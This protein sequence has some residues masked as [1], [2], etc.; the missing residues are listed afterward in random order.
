MP[1]R[2]TAKTFGERAR[3]QVVNW[4]GPSAYASRVSPRCPPGSR[5]ARAARPDPAHLGL[6][7]R[8]RAGVVGIWGGVAGLGVAAGLLA[9]GVCLVRLRSGGGLAQP[10]RSAR[11]PARSAGPAR[12]RAGR[13]GSAAA[14]DSAAAAPGGRRRSRIAPPHRERGQAR[15]RHRAHSRR[16]PTWGSFL[17]W[18]GRAAAVLDGDPTLLGERLDTGCAAELAVTRVLHAAKGGHG[19]IADAL[20]VDVDYP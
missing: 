14:A 15:V 20:I 3:H 9:G 16:V 10:R 6:S 1:A 7:G 19:L 17:E 18:I 4:R 11:P 13:S 12:P 2:R 8:R 5:R